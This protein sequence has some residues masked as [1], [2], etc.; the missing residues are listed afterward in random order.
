VN[1]EEREPELEADNP[2][3]SGGPAQPQPKDWLEHWRTEQELVVHSESFRIWH[4]IILVAV[5]AV[6]C[7]LVVE[8]GAVIV[9]FTIFALI[10][11]AVGSGVMIARRRSTQ[12]DSLLH[13]LAIAAERGMPL[14]PTVAAFA[15]QYGGKYRRRIM[16][17][18]AQLDS[19]CSVPEALERVP[20]VVSR[21][22]L[23]LAHAG[24]RT[25]RLAQALRMAASSRAS[26]LPIW[27]AI[28]SRFAYLLFLLLTIQIICGFILYFIIPKFEAIFADFGVPL[29][30]VTIFVI[31]SAHF[32]TNYGLITGWVPGIEILLLVFLPFSFAGWVNYD[33]PFFDRLLKRRHTA[34]LLR[35]LSLSVEAG[36]PI[37]TGLS[38]LSSHYPTWWVRRRL[39][40][41]DNEVQHGGSWIDALERQ[42]LI[43]GTDAEV[44][45]AAARVGN[46]AWAMQE[47]A[48][49]GERRLAFRFQ[50]VIQTLF[51]LI[52]I[53]LGV[54]VFLLAFAFF[55]PLVDLIRRLAG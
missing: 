45:D 36:Q 41:V 47:L 3:K 8:M 16:N 53:S 52:V 40:K 37:E 54:F 48:E 46:L 18:A 14:A 2:Y 43:R 42:A 4:M 22:A 32:I 50:G 5:V 38:T 17:L 21:D 7:W 10:A 24:Q 49:T 9:P 13:I 28:A 44:L 39:I 6:Y 33:V 12:Q 26:H 34:L 27:M 51:P 15:D 20:R 55:S 35:S 11:L 23:L 30:A 1:H 19:G 25:G 31:Q 29:P